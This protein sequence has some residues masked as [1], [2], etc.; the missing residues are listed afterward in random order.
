[1][2]GKH[3]GVMMKS[4]RE[5]DALGDPLYPFELPGKIAIAGFQTLGDFA[6]AIGVD[7]ARIFRIICGWEWPNEKTRV[8]MPGDEKDDTNRYI[9]IAAT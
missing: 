4:S 5:E 1:L 8:A 7:S 9:L 2:E 3:K 6:R